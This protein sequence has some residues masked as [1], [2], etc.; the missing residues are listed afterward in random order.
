MNP[1]AFHIFSWPVY[2]YG[3]MMATAFLAGIANWNFFARR[4]GREHGFGS[5]LAFWMMV[6]GI[7]GARVAYVAANFRDFAADPLEII[8]IYR[9]GLVF[10]GGLIGAAAG[11][12]GVARARREPLLPM[13]DLAVS[14]LPLG[15]TIGRIGCFLNGCCYGSPTD[16]A[17]GVFVE[18]ALRHPTQLYE[19]AFNGAVYLLVFILFLRRP[20]PGTVLACYLLAYPPGRFAIEFLRGD[21]RIHWLGLTAAQLTSLALFGIGLA[22]WR[23][24]RRRPKGADSRESP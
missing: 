12:V 4:Q 24:L 10:Y 5:E 18:G 19:A 17:C 11:V 7:V 1:V 6:C 14:A 13:A 8:R 9:G 16:C 21:P 22:L 3:I 20:K 23:W 15:H 2:W